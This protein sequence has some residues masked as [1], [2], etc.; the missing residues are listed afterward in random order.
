[1]A[2]SVRDTLAGVGLTVGGYAVHLVV[3]FLFALAL[4][5]LVTGPQFATQ[6]VAESLALNTIVAV[7]V[8][9]PIFEE[10]FVCGYIVTA[11]KERRGVT[12]AVNLS[13]ALRVTYHLYQGPLG[14]LAIAPIGLIFAYWYARTNRLWPV[15][16]AHGAMDLIGLAVA[17]G[18]AG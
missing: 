16:V 2:P 17:S 14:V 13:T 1:L 10:V 6:L 15:I 3:L 18:V 8:V 11:L 4:P 5:A 7:S 12:F 9:N